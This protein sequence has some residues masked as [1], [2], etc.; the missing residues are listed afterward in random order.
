MK[1]E[2]GTSPAKWKPF[3]ASD[4]ESVVVAIAV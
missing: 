4:P 3:E 1:W 2:K